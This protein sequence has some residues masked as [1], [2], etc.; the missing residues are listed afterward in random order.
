LRGRISRGTTA[1][2]CI[3][4]AN[5]TTAEARERLRI[6]ARTTNGFTLAEQDAKL[7]G[8]G[9]FFGTR[10][11]GLGELRFGD[12]LGDRELLTQARRDAFALVGD[13]AGL[14]RPEHRLLRQLVVERYGRTLDLATVG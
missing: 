14:V 4:F 10:Q 2:R 5:P 9:E 1:G 7:R 13:D 8:L 3:V 6:F 12:L 11:H